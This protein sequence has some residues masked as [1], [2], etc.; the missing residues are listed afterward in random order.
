MIE[1]SKIEKI[2]LEIELKRE[3]LNMTV[4]E[5]LNRDKILRAS[6]ELDLLIVEY[7]SVCKE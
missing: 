3:E 5:S 4:A 7:Y 2:K 1:N 6:Q